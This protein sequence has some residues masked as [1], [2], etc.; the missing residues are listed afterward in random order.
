MDKE[1]FVEK[2]QLEEVTESID[3]NV[4]AAVVEGYSDK[5]ILE[6]LGF[7]GKIFLSA[8]KKLEDLVEDVSRGSNKVAVLTD[9]DSHGK[10]Q[11]KEITHELRKEVDVLESAREKF[12][13]QLTS[14]GRRDV[15]D[16]RPLFE[17]RDEKFV[18]AALDQ[19]FLGES[20][21]DVD[22]TLETDP[23]RIAEDLPG[24]Y[25]TDSSYPVENT[26]GYDTGTGVEF[27]DG[28]V[29]TYSGLKAPDHMLST[30]V[31]IDRAAK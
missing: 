7:T 26:A 23:E 27:E 10:E 28:L 24:N 15:E 2:K 17:D 19:L 5:K 31:E 20:R 11:G 12:G 4:D 9:F 8:E 29:E 1:Q 25:S 6:K 22:R 3:H 18:D 13:R 14:T 30:L 21:Q 16:A